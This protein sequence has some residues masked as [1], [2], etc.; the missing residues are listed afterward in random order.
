MF[1][2]AAISFSA[3]ATSSPW[4]RLSSWHGPAITDS[5]RLLPNRT[6]PMVTTGA[7]ELWSLKIWSFDASH[8]LH[9]RERGRRQQLAGNVFDDLAVFLTFRTRRDPV[10]IGQERRPFRFAL[11][12]RFPGQ[13]IGQL[14]VGFADQGREEADRADR[15][16]LPELQRGVLKPFQQR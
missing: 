15:M 6:E 16:L 13:E 12:E 10:G 9:Q 2:R 8:S 5:G 1:R 4:A 7:A 3:E 14:L 11:G